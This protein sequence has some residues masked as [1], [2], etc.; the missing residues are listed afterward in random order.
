MSLEIGCRFTTRAL[1]TIAALAIS[2]AQLTRAQSA[3]VPKFEVVSIRPWPPGHAARQDESRVGTTMANFG[4]QLQILVDRDVIYKTGISGNFDIHVEMPVED[5][6]A[7]ASVGTDDAAPHSP[8]D[9]SALAF[10]AVRKLG[11]KLE[12]AQG[13]GEVFRIDHIERPG[14][15]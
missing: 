1:S 13:F 10:A 5:L 7:D 15:N 3:P 2:C 4:E 6:A 8:A 12:S 11:L 9:E 14:E